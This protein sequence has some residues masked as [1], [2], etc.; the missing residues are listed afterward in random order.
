[1]NN[2]PLKVYQIY[3]ERLHFHKDKKTL[4]TCSFREESRIINCALL[5][6]KFVLK[7]SYR[8]KRNSSCFFFPNP[9]ERASS[10]LE[11]AVAPEAR[12]PVGSCCIKR[13]RLCFKCR[14]AGITERNILESITHSY[15]CCS[16]AYIHQ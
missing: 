8:G 7:F 10:A 6:L 11:I 14:K 2:L 1:M 15:L 16:T 12:M 13:N 3:V 4:V 9:K 5:K